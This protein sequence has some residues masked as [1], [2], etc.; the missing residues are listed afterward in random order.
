MN[1]QDQEKTKIYNKKKVANLQG[2][3]FDDVLLVPQYSEITPDQTKTTTFLTKKIQLKNP[4]ISAAM[5]TISSKE[6]AIAMALSGGVGVIH[7]N[8]PLQ[9][10]TNLINEIKNYQFTPKVGFTPA[11]DSQNRLLVG[12][13]VS[14]EPEPY[15]QIQALRTVGVDFV[16]LDSAHGHSKNIINFLKGIKK[17]FPDLQVIA[18]N[19][20]TPA[21]AHDLIMAGADALKVGIGPGSICTTRIVAGVGV[22]QFSAIAQVAKVAKSFEIPVIADG[23]IK[24]SGDIVKALGIGANTVMIGSLLA[25]TDQT[26]GTVIEKNGTKYK[27]YIGMG[28]ITAMNNGSSDRY[29]QN[30]T[31]K[32][33]P[34]GV[35]TLVL[36][37][38][39][40][41]EVLYQLIGGLR[42]GMGY[43]GAS[44][45]F[46]IFNK[47]K[48]ITITSAGYQESLPHIFNTK[49]LKK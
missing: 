1:Y 41:F 3:T 10:Q 6:M 21:A 7:K 25:G 12:A 40:V 36:C 29:N 30:P 34:E 35:E 43:L 4:I 26:P 44:T 9:D 24:S 5:D 49:R 2:L 48:F 38:G 14:V 23:G 42:S 39:D 22:P 15:Y 8:M 17:S 18:G 47:A 11:V 16:V 46:E 13:A 32:F 31:K 37:K 28:S 27:K 45:V 20:V 33:V 19:I